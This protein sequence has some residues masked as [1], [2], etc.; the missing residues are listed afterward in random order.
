MTNSIYKRK[1]T[2]IYNYIKEVFWACPIGKEDAKT[3]STYISIGNNKT[4][5]ISDHVKEYKHTQILINPFNNYY[6]LVTKE[7]IVPLTFNQ[8]KLMLYQNINNGLNTIG[9]IITK[10]NVRNVQEEESEQ[11]QQLMKENES[12]VSYVS[13]PEC[14]NFLN[15]ITH[16]QY[17]KLNESGKKVLDGYLKGKIYTN[18][19]LIYLTKNQVKSLKRYYV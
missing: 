4:I 8:L 14:T 17:L 5:R 13:S 16:E 1:K 11:I 15:Y 9:G 19:Q 10:E 12:S 7:I 18:A 2:L 3:G 6:T